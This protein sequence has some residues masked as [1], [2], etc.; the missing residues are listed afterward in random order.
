MDHNN[1]KKLCPY[2]PESSLM[3]T[4]PQIDENTAL[5]NKSTK[6]KMVE[7]LDM[8]ESHVE[9]LRKE[10]AHLEEEKDTILASLDALKH[11][12]TVRTIDES[13]SDFFILF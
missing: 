4:L 10:A 2:L 1:C 13:K 7:M 11:T 8:L 9:K 3:M 12:D 6:E 5:E